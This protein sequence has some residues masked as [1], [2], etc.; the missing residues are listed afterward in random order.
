MEQKKEN[1]EKKTR[2]SDIDMGNVLTQN[3]TGY[4]KVVNSMARLSDT[5]KIFDEAIFGLQTQIRTS[6]QS[7]AT[8]MIQNMERE[9]ILRDY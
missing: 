5:F 8:K 2:K 6:L 7:V 9:K 1:I 3:E 4:T